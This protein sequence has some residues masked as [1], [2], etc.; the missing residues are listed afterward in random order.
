[1]K[2]CVITCV[3]LPQSLSKEVKGAWKA[4]RTHLQKLQRNW[5]QQL[6]IY[7]VGGDFNQSST[8]EGYFGQIEDFEDEHYVKRVS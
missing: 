1:M 4:L 3:H 2:T 8:E 6:P 5:Q 7:I